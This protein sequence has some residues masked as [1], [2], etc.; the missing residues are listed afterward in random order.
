[1]GKKKRKNQP[2]YP[3]PAAA[4]ASAGW[5][6]RNTGL[7]LAAVLAVGLIIRIVALINLSGTVYADYLL[8]DERIYHKWAKE[9]AAGTFHSNS[10]YEFAPLPA[11][12]MAFVYRLISPDAYHI[13][14]LNIVFGTLSCW[15]I[16]LTGKELAGRKVGLLS[17]LIACL[18]KPFILYSIVP[19]KESL[20]LVLFLLVTYL[21]VKV[22]SPGDSGA[23]RKD[24][25]QTGNLIRI[26]FLGAAAG[27]VLNARPNAVVLVPVIPLI[28]FWYG[29]RDRLP[30]KK[31][32]KDAAVYGAGLC[33]A[34]APF[35]IRNY[36]V[37]GEVALTTSQAGF[38]LYLGNNLGNPDPYY[39]PAPFASSSP[40]EQGIQF[41]IEA[42]RRAGKKLTS[43]EASDY[44]TGE[45]LKEATAHP[46]AFAWKM[47]Q[48]LLV[49]VNRFEACDHY[50]TDFI[51]DFAI[52]FKAP[53]V[54]FWVIFPLSMAGI[55]AL[56]KE[57]KT[58]A[59]VALISVYAATLVVFFTTARYRL[60]IAAVLIPFAA[61]EICILLSDFREKKYGKVA[62]NVVLATFFLVIAFLPVRGTDNRTAYFNTHAI[63][64]ASKEKEDEAI[65]Y[66]KMSSEMG[67][68]FSAFADLAL[69]GRYF[70][71]GNIGEATAY[72]A[73]IQ[74]DSFAAAGKYE[75]LGDFFFH[76]RKMDEAIAAFEKS[77]SIN[78][79]QRRA[80][81]KLIALY[82]IKNPQ[83]AAQEE[84][85]L[86]YI[87]SFYDLM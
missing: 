57:R 62:G 18:Y 44:W 30:W 19:L 51:S 27:L 70:R 77:I 34:V 29:Y 1:M 86:T 35:V 14:I 36:M 64:L 76:E 22:L 72:L 21:L 65:Q 39:R 9:I 28:L 69:G 78:Y 75:L 2:V 47:G 80:R 7:V 20:S 46:T 60:P 4:G 85:T 67:K 13:R 26:G 66:W 82:K 11:Y 55:L 54:V 38:N 12:V 16:Y 49:L 84:K 42:S 23:E 48:K 3:A 24:M 81:E 61:A 58:R 37:A 71:R 56:R 25:Q 74:D 6:D 41:T 31:L 10:V 50:D 43:R 59:L 83:M 45:V 53:F 8:W 40:F 33:I 17:C 5:L 63:I 32:L 52:V 87:K 15:L 73:K 68:P 79:G